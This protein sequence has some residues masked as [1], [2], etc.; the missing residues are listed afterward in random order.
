MRKSS[1]LLTVVALTL[2]SVVSGSAEASNWHSGFKYHDTSL[3][4]DIYWRWNDSTDMKQDMAGINVM[5]SIPMTELCANLIQYWSG[6]DS[7]DIW[8]LYSPYLNFNGLPAHQYTS[9]L[10]FDID[11]GTWYEYT[12]PY[13]HKHLTK[14]VV[15]FVRCDSSY[16]D[17]FYRKGVWNGYAK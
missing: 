12:G 3:G 14:T 9:V 17:N 7:P 10:F 1:I 16:P 13:F 15:Q 6:S 11:P 5:A 2:S 4:F 8:P